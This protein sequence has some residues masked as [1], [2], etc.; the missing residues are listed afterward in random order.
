M[1]K[2][3][4]A[5]LPIVTFVGSQAM[6]AYAGE[7]KAPMSKC[8]LFVEGKRYQETQDDTEPKQYTEARIVD[9]VL[10][11]RNLVATNFR[12]VCGF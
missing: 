8:Y 11:Y 9:G 1:K 4:L 10:Y 5:M 7:M 3:L 2:L 12:F 6:P